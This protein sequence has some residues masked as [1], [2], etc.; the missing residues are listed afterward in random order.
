MSIEQKGLNLQIL[1]LINFKGK[2]LSLL[3]L[4][5]SFQIT[6]DLFSS[7][8]Y[9]SITITD[10]HDLKHNFPLIGE[11]RLKVKFK[12][13]NKDFNW[14]EK[15]FYV[16]AMPNRS[17][18][19]NSAT[20]TTLAFS[21]EEMLL[22]RV[23]LVSKSFRDM[24]PSTLIKMVLKDLPTAKDVITEDTYGIQ[25][26]ISPNIHPFEIIQSMTVRAKSK[27]F[28]ES[29]GFLFY[30][31]LDGFNFKSLDNLIKNSKVTDYTF[32]K[33]G[34]MEVDG[35]DKFYSILNYTIQ[36]NYD[37]LQNINTGM[38]G[39]TTHAFDIQRRKYD[40]IEYNYFKDSDYTKT[41]HLEGSDPD[42]RLQTSM[43]P[44]ADKVSGSMLKF[45]PRYSND[46]LRDSNLS[47]R[48]AQISQI[49]NGFI[50]VAE[51]NGN[52]NIRVGER[53]KLKHPSKLG[54]DVE[55]QNFDRFLSGFYLITS[56]AH[57]I[58]QDKYS[59]SIELTKD[60]YAANHEEFADEMFAKID[61]GGNKN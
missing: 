44:F 56:I 42:L 36:S 21:S 23:Q 39:N 34:T 28:T 22:N 55:K 10:T 29:S 13:P 46:Q 27:E 12:T 48:Y 1:D 60:S 9:G 11:E 45:V 57:I 24:D 43:F 33:S 52:S 58:T 61:L 25:T 51:I 18:S 59:C 32:Q 2:K 53:V 3:S 31:S 19:D 41:Q 49:V 17:E 38:Y 20:S 4:F 7:V 14:I 6:E 50:M 47:T 15:E 16:Y 54:D 35:V 26:Y 30:E 40:V 37:I 5:E 8:L